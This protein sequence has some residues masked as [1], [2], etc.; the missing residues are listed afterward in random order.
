MANALPPPC[1]G[2]AQFSIAARDYVEPYA[3]NSRIAAT[4][5]KTFLL[6][7]SYSSAMFMSVAC[8]DAAQMYDI[9]DLGTL[10]GAYRPQGLDTR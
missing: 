2:A 9:K 10:G 5:K 6:G 3:E 1:K 7:A 8:A 4:F